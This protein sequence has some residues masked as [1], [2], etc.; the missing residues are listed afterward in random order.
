MTLSDGTEV[1]EFPVSIVIYDVEQI[2]G[3]QDDSQVDG[4]DQ[5]QTPDEVLEPTDQDS[6]LATEN[7]NLDGAS[8][9]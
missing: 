7:E 9:I 3:E 1:R 4:D 6:E 8:E 2:T 5:D